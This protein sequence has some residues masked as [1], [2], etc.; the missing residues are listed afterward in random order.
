[1]NIGELSNIGHIY[2]N[3]NDN[4]GLMPRNDLEWLKNF[5]KFCD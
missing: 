3:C 1:M 2:I 4:G 5:V